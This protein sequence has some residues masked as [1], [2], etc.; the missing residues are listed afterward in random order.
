MRPTALFAEEP[1]GSRA[2]E[3]GKAVLRRFWRLLEKMG[4]H[5]FL[6]PSMSG[7]LPSLTTS[8]GSQTGE[9]FRDT[10]GFQALSVLARSL[11]GA[12]AGCDGCGS[13]DRHGRGDWAN[14][15]PCLRSPTRLPL[16]A[17]PRPLRNSP[18]DARYKT[19]TF[20]PSASPSSYSCRLPAP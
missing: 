13:P 1:T 3:T 4:S 17:P 11:H 8:P 9:S 6:S 15:R 5:P 19:A 20:P 2:S 18:V 7:R 10:P 14:R 12:C 16:S